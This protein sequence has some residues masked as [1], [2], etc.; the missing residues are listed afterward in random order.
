MA[1]GGYISKS[2]QLTNQLNAAKNTVKVEPS[3]VKN[4]LHI[5][6]WLKNAVKTGL[7]MEAMRNLNWSRSYL[8]YCELDGVPAPFHRGGVLGLPCTNVSYSLATGETMTIN[9]FMQDMVIPKR[10]GSFPSIQLDLLEDE[11]G[12]LMEFF[13]R[14][15]NQIYNPYLGV[16]PIS[17][18]CKQLTIYRQKTTRTNIKR[19]YYNI[20]KSLP[21]IC[22]EAVKTIT[23]SWFKGNWCKYLN[24]TSTEGLDFLVYP[25]SDFR[26]S[27]S[28]E[29]N[30]LIKLSVQLEVAQFV[31]Q[32][33][34]DPSTHEG[35]QILGNLVNKDS[36]SHGNSFL[37]KIADYI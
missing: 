23:K 22:G 25:S 4:P 27:Q 31:N 5:G 14:W 28:A 15:Y 33:F 6:D 10:V 13:E 9:S 30:G 20:D 16:L 37:D 26:I 29:E 12:T 11:Q 3:S 18:A 8:Y 1:L 36:L 21:T 32:D 17:E 19:I 7:F 24:K 35:Y 34:G 2:D